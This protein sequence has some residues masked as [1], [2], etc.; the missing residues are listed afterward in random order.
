MG[1]SELIAAARETATRCMGVKPGENVLVIMERG[2]SERIAEAVA[3]ACAGLGAEVSI[4]SYYPRAGDRV[5]HSAEYQ[6]SINQSFLA[7]PPPK[8]LLDAMSSSDA[9]FF[10]SAESYPAD[11]IVKTLKKGVRVLA[12]FQMSESA[13]VRTLL[14]DH[15]SMGN[16]AARLAKAFAGAKQITVTSKSGTNLVFEHSSQREIVYEKY[17]GLC[18]EPGRMGQLPP[19]MVATSPREGSGQGVIVVDGAIFGVLRPIN[20][21]VRLQ[22]VDHKIVQVEGG[23]AIGR[24]LDSELDFYDPNCRTIPAEWGIG[25]NPGAVLGPDIEGE[26]AYGTVHFGVG[27]NSHVGGGAVESNFHADLM[28]KG[29]T[30]KADGVVLLE[31]GSFVL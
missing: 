9:I 16:L 12:A 7:T 1:M 26:T 14:V 11:A 15:E 27:R 18:R 31:S 3:G 13:F 28:I 10:Q 23:G 20:E 5:G 30:V 25:L 17:L 6:V 29:A 4:A 8:P 2:T 22:V 24:A 21:P 19:G